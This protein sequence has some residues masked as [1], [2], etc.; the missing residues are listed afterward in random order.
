MVTEKIQ[1]IYLGTKRVSFFGSLI[2]VEMEILDV[3][4]L[5]LLYTTI[6][7]LLMTL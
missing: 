2:F 6:L 4:A 7:F 3:Q 5:E 1:I